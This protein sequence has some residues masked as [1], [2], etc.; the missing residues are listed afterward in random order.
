[1]ADTTV[2]EDLVIA[3]VSVVDSDGGIEEFLHERALGGLRREE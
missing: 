2:N 3:E 1:M